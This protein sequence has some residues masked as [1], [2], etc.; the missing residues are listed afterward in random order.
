M[1]ESYLGIDVHKKVCV[2]AEIDSKGKI[3]HRGKFNN[4]I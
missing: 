2:F 3:V 4:T 1:S